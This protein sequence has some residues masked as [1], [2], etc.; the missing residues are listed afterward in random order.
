[1]F[2]K[3]ARSQMDTYLSPV[4]THSARLPVALGLFSTKV[5]RLGKKL[6]LS[7]ETRILVRE[8][9]ARINSATSPDTLGAI[10]GE[11]FS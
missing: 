11:G 2:N 9:V 10:H 7:S 3:M 5:S 8:E 6:P 1:M 4:A